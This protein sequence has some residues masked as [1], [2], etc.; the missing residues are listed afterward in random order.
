[1]KI[2]LTNE[3]RFL[4]LE[5]III[6]S[7]FLVISYTHFSKYLVLSHIALHMLV[8]SKQQSDINHIA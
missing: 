3:M 4:G 7:S 8:M 2:R 1:M 6:S 5:F